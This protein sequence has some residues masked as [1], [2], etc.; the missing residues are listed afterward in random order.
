VE[1]RFLWVA[2]SLTAAVL[3]IHRTPPKG[4]AYRIVVGIGFDLIAIFK[5]ATR[6]LIAISVVE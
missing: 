2:I 4:R 3:V 5:A 6:A 1:L